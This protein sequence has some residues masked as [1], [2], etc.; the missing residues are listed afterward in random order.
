MGLLDG[1]VALITGGAQGIGLAIGQ[2]FATE[3]A[4]LVLADRN[5][6]A[7]IEAAQAIDGDAIGCGADVVQPDDV[8]AMVAATLEAYGRIDVLVNN[9]GITRDASLKN[10]TLEQFR[11]VIDVHLQGTWLGMKEVLPRMKSQGQGGAIINMSSISGKVG[12]FGQSNYA[13]AKAGIVAM[14][15]SVARE[16]A[17]DGIRVNAIQPGLIDSDMTRAMPPDILAAT[18]AEVPMRR[19]GTPEEVAGVAV[20]LASDLSSYC[21]GITIEVA[22][23]RHM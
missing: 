14:T 5:R 13:A 12:N 2:R 10:M 1:K 19:A 9:A 11:Q 8:A 17:K 23:G 7:A 16:G 21:T 18:Q 3:G 20:F 4:R 22:G 15:K 6:E